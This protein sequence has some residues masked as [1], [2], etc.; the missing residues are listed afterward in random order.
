MSSEIG[1]SRHDGGVRPGDDVPAAAR[2]PR[3]A[4]TE[5][6]QD[7]PPPT[8]AM[9]VA[10]R[11]RTHNDSPETAEFGRRPTADGM[12]PDA[13]GGSPDDGMYAE[14]SYRDTSAYRPEPTL[15][16]ELL[17]Q[18]QHNAYGGLRLGS[19]FFGWL[20]AT[21]LIV[22][23]SAIAAGAAAVFGLANEAD[24][25][26]RLDN[27]F[28]GNGPAAMIAGA[29][30]AAGILIAYF[31]GGYVAG[32]MARFD[33]VRQGFAVWLWALLMAVIAGVIGLS[34]GGLGLLTGPAPVIDRPIG[35]LAVPGLV[36]LAVVLLASLAGALL[37]GAAG[38][39]YH[40]AIDRAGFVPDDDE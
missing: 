7:E 28:A 25:R 6:A 38:M 24:V 19:A 8:E 18:R 27:I 20:A 10:S 11:D 14:R 22:L 1:S 30:L 15:D 39:H 21:A 4:G 3:D 36:A 16:E 9:P 5:P 32:R 34:A 33:G 26:G 37:G 13:A 29:A 2:E 31:A 35:Q 23:L 12:D 17:Y 40:R